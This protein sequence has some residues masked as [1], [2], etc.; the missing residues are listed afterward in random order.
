VANKGRNRENS[1]RGKRTIEVVLEV[2]ELTRAKPSDH[3]VL[4]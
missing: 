2:I 3:G 4:L 1:L